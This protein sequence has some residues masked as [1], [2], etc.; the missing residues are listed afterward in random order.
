MEKLHWYSRIKLRRE[1]IPRVQVQSCHTHWAPSSGW[2]WRTQARSEGWGAV[3]W[4]QAGRSPAFQEAELRCHPR[5]LRGQ[6]APALRDLRLKRPAKQVCRFLHMAL[7]SSLCVHQRSERS[8][9][10]P[11]SSRALAGRP[12]CGKAGPLRRCLGSQRALGRTQTRL[13]SLGHPRALVQSSWRA[14]NVPRR[15]R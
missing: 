3:C 8:T 15:V 12:L 10:A 7:G 5:P 11:R 14:L 6:T 4:P 13:A 1:Y 9:T 2:P